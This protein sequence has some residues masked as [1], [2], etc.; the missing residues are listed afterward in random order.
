M[1]EREK[2]IKNGPKVC[3]DEAKENGMG[4]EAPRES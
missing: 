4:T 3:L 1:K 2:Q